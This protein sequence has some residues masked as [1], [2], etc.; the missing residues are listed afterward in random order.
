MRGILADINIQGQFQAIVEQ[1]FQS[2]EWSEVWADLNL[3]VESFHTLG[4]ALDADDDL[5][6]QTCQVRELV[7]FTANRNHDGSTSLE[8]TILQRNSNQSYPVVTISD[9]QRFGIVRSYTEEA[10]IRLLDILM[11]INNYRGCGR[12]YIP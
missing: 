7:L 10:A 11:D 3:K 8:A 12:I 5:L 6:W 4:L 2:S 9:P 1:I